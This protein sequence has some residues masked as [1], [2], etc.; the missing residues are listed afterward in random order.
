MK[1]K[2]VLKR[3]FMFVNCYRGLGNVNVNYCVGFGWLVM[4]V[5]DFV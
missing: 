3:Y 5:G 2:L 4:V 1:W